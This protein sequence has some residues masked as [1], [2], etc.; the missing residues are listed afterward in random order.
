[1]KHARRLEAL[2]KRYHQRMQA[3]VGQ[4]IGEQPL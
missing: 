4:R 1:M 2:G 3:A